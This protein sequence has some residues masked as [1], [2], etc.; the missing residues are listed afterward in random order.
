[1]VRGLRP[2][3][4][5]AY[6]SE[7]A[8]THVHVHMHEHLPPAHL[9]IRLSACLRICVCVAVPNTT[10]AAVWS[11]CFL[12]HASGRGCDTAAVLH[13]VLAPAFR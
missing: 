13:V 10:T 4:Q 8:A 12:V 2:C 5:C 11:L 7:G 3:W 9:F 1:M 6:L